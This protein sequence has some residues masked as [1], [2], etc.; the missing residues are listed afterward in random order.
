MNKEREREKAR[1]RKKKALDALKAQGYKAY[2]IH[3]NSDN[4]AYLNSVKSKLG[5]TND[6][7]I[8]HIFQVC[9][10]HDPQ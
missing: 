5:L 6:Q 1:T 2:F 7:A 3:L 4:T 8:D 10:E 9:K